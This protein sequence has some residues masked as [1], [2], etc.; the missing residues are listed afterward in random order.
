MAFAS[1][2]PFSFKFIVDDGLIGGD[3]RLLITIVAGLAIGAVAVSA[4]GLGRDFLFARLVAQMLGDVRAAMF[5]QLQRL[6]LDYFSRARVGDVLGR[7]SGDLGSV[8][9]ALANAI[10]WGILPALDV[11]ANTALLFWLDW[12]L[13]LVAM[14]MWPL[15]LLGPRFFVPRALGASY[16]RK[17]AEGNALALVQE[18]VQSQP[19]VQALNLQREA[20][21]QFDRH[22]RSLTGSLRRSSFLSALVER[23]AGIGIMLLQVLILAIGAWMAASELM[24]VG[25][26]TAF[27]ALF[28]NASLSLA[29]ATQFMPTLVNA[30]GGMQRIDELLDARPRV[31]DLPDAV[32]LAA[33]G[34][35]IAFEKVSFG[36]NPAMRNLREL[37]VEIPATASVAFV[38]ASGSG[39]STVLA[40]LMRLYE[41]DE[42]RIVFDG[43]DLRGATQESLRAQIGVVFQDSFLFNVSVADNIRLGRLDATLVEIEAAARAAEIHDVIAALPEAYDT[44]IGERGGRL[45]G[46]QRQRIAI[47]RVLLRDPR[48]LVLDEATS[49]LDPATEAAINE[50]VS[51][52]GRNRMVVSVTH[53]LTTAAAAD[54]IHVLEEG[55]LVESGRH[56]ELLARGGV[57]ARLWA[58]QSGF[59][60]ADDGHVVEVTPHRLRQIALFDQLDDLTLREAAALFA[61]ERHPEGRSVIYQGDEGDRFYVLV[62][63][64]VEVLIDD[65]GGAPR[66]IAVL[67]DGD[68]FGELALLRPVPRN[69][70]VRT[71]MPCTLLSLQRRQFDVLLQRAPQLRARMEAVHTARIAQ[72]KIA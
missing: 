8:E 61:T 46:G 33:L 42:G 54:C 37:S 17:Q 43:V 55:R 28:L 57:Y 60:L 70:T 52:I 62:R 15:C 53:R 29:Y 7:F 25:T 56:G 50:T 31:S 20:T 51:R 69:A 41:P 21:R 36:Y 24:T 44:L 10:P 12:R 48:I 16:A 64:A 67:Q 47:A 58:K 63:G 34:G 1:A 49:A 14:L 68:H 3:Y 45:S 35:K 71:L 66:R 38:G 65:A 19:I 6:S 40:L 32:K 13:A 9:A 59:H 2:L 39:K 72:S 5:G 30:T 18:N 11:L 22:N 27:L 23:S 26:L 4:I